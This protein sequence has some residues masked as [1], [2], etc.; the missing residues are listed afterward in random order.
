MILH[1]GAKVETM[2]E[3]IISQPVLEYLR[4]FLKLVDGRILT[5]TEFIDALED[6][7][8]GLKINP[9]KKLADLYPDEVEA[10]LL[11]LSIASSI[12]EKMDLLKGT[13]APQI[14]LSE[15]PKILYATMFHGVSGKL[16]SAIITTAIVRSLHNLPIVGD[17]C[18]A[19]YNDEL[20]VC[21]GNKND[22]NCDT[23]NVSSPFPYDLEKWD[24]KGSTM[25]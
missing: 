23:M 8:K 3:S 24:P 16:T 6:S 9:E 5:E 4:S 17:I 14:D 20:C 7:R 15:L 25:N 10:I 12:D 1:P 22:C 13:P 2:E 18:L 19:I 11:E 21:C